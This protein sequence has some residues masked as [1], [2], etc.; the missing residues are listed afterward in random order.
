[1]LAMPVGRFQVL[2]EA[3]HRR[4]AKL[5][6]QALLAASYP[7]MSAAGRR[8]VYSALLAQ[9]E[10]PEERQ[11]RWDASWEKLDR[12]LSRRVGDSARGVSDGL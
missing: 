4:R 10:T 6:L 8:A 3:A 5:Q 9:S 1:M 7:H 2:L 11:A 12:L